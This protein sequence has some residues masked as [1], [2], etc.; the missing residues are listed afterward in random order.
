MPRQNYQ[1]E[2]LI[3]KLF[4]GLRHT[5]IKRPCVQC[6]VFRINCTIKDSRA[7]LIQ[8][9]ER[10][11]IL[12][13]MKTKNSVKSWKIKENTNRTRFE[14]SYQATISKTAAANEEIRITV[15]SSYFQNIGFTM[16]IR[17]GNY[18]FM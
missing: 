1:N 16:N 13:I 15:H 7:R 8:E 5:N 17:L 14:N 2:G 11:D 18:T 9:I 3:P 6:N 10:E 12:F 4:A